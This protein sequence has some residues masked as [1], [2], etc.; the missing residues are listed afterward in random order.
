M[1]DAVAQEIVQRLGGVDDAALQ[2]LLF[3]AEGAF[4]GVEMY[5]TGEYALQAVTVL[6]AHH[7]SLDV[8]LLGGQGVAGQP[9]AVGVPHHQPR[10]SG[11]GVRVLGAIPVPG[12]QLAIRI[13]YI[14]PVLQPGQGRIRVIQQPHAVAV[15]RVE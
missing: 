12:N 13:R 4:I 7:R 8:H 9:A 1:I 15:Q 11:D 3:E 10:R 6:T 2:Q 14:Y 5:R